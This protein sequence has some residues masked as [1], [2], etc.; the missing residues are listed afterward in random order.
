MRYVDLFLR[1]VGALTAAHYVFQK[2]KIHNN[3]V[4]VEQDIITGLIV[5][6]LSMT[7]DI[8]QKWKKRIK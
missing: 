3:P 2:L 7:F 4:N 6:L 8:V 5:I 1:F